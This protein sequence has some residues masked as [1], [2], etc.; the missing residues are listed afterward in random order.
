MEEDAG[1]DRPFIAALAISKAHG[2]LPAPGFFDC[3]R[4]LGRFAGDPD[5]QD[6]W[7]FHAAELNAVFARWVGSRPQFASLPLVIPL[8]RSTSDEAFDQRI[9]PRWDRVDV[10]GLG[11]GPTTVSADIVDPGHPIGVHRGRLLLGVLAAIALDLDDQIQRI[12][13]SVVDPDDEVWQVSFGR[14]TVEIGHLETEA[15]VFDV[16]A[17]T[18]VRLDDT[19]EFGFPIAVAN[20][21]I[22]MAATVIGFP[23]RGFRGREVDEASR[24]GRVV[25]IEDGLDRTLANHRRSN[26]CRNAIA[27]HIGDLRIENLGLLGASAPEVSTFQPF[28]GDPLQLAEQVNLRLLSGVTELAEQQVLRQAKKDGRSPDLVEMFD[29]QI[30]WFADNATHED[31][32]TCI[33]LMGQEVLPAV[34]E[35]AKELGLKSPFETNQPVSVEYM[36]GRAQVGGEPARV[37][38][39]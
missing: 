37:A 34:R 10:G 12:V 27:G 23:A 13:M 14:R 21:P 19:T 6:A 11:K 20:D 38:A 32:K 2:G 17:H 26:R 7:S 28:T 36:P 22:H 39:E 33:R 1:A 31:A 5:G 16:G 35:T 4:R 8:C 15:L 25:G 24:T 30:D 18:R 29:G 9:E 3:A